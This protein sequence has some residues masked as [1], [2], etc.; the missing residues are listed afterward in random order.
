MI[1]ELNFGGCPIE[2]TYKLGDVL[3]SKT[4][5][6][7][8]HFYYDTAT[9]K[10]I[11]KYQIMHPEDTYQEATVLLS[12]PNNY[13]NDLFSERHFYIKKEETPTQEEISEDAVEKFKHFM[14]FHADE[15]SSKLALALSY[16]EPLDNFNRH[17]IIDESTVT[18]YKGKEKN[19]MSY[20]GS[21]K[22]E[23][24][25]TGS[26]K[27]ET[28]GSGSTDDTVTHQV[29]AENSNSF[30]SGNESRDV[31]KI[32]DNNRKSTTT[33]SFTNYKETAETSYNNRK[34]SGTRSFEDREDESTHKADNHLFGN[35]GITTSGAMWLESYRISELRNF[36]INVYKKF[37][38]EYTNV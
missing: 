7:A 20:T 28:V 23:M 19:E 12:F 11:P 21:A 30:E 6:Q 8:V 15:I 13:V 9:G 38:N 18:D 5:T 32:E 1:N 26:R 27:S 10:Y 14:S 4:T 22:T 17:E 16:Y 35:I 2:W 24:T 33:D 29:V 3:E 37:I 36:A 31:R 34:D 25:P